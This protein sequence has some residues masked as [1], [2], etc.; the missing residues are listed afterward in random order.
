MAKGNEAAAVNDAAMEDPAGDILADAATPTKSAAEKTVETEGKEK[1]GGGGGDKKP[2]PIL[3]ANQK[4]SSADPKDK[5]A[6]SKGEAKS[7]G[8]GDDKKVKVDDAQ[9]DKKAVPETYDLKLPDGSYLDA[10]DVEETKAFAKAQ[11]LSQE[12]AQAVLDGRNAAVAEHIKA[13]TK[14]GAAW[15]QRTESWGNEALTDKEIGGSPEK[16]QG[17]LELGNRVVAEYFP[18]SV[19]EFLKESGFN[20]HPDVIRGFVRIAQEMAPAKT[21]H[22]SHSTGKERSME[23]HFYG[24]ESKQ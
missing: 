6:Q 13:N 3:E 7:E 21:V 9:G 2:E 4:D 10:A 19:H 20:R 11:G 15:T 1:V 14:G 12:T 17:S 22:S 16:L 8:S 18:E 5:A 24:E 23:E